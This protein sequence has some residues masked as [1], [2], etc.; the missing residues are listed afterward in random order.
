[1]NYLT[2]ILGFTELT[3]K[4]VPEGSLPQRY[5]REVWQSAK[6]GAS[7]VHKLQSLSQAK[8]TQFEPTDLA[9]VLREET[10]RLRPLW[11]E[12]VT[13]VTTLEEPLPRLE[14]AREPL[15]QILAQLLDNAREAIDG[16]GD[17][18]LAARSCQLGPV[19]SEALLGNPR[20]GTFVEITIADTG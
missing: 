20:P 10:D 11:G 8:P 17:V 6:D 18:T 9:S 7:W 14:V 13:L 4:H 2:G 19:E 15:R 1:G 16:P 5:L 12:A 3:A